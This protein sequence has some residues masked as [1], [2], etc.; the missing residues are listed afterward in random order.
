[1]DTIRLATEALIR[2]FQAEIDPHTLLVAADDVFEATDV[3]A[4]LLQSRRKK[5]HLRRAAQH[6][7]ARHPGGDGLHFQSPGRRLAA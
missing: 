5:G 4:L 1:M 7:H 2:L 6:P 3:P